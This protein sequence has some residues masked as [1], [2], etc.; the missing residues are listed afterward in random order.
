MT[1]QI[2][3]IFSLLR[4][5]R[6]FLRVLRYIIADLTNSPNQ[7][8][9]TLDHNKWDFWKHSPTGITGTATRDNGFIVVQLRFD[10]LRLIGVK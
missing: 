10:P 5:Y 6:P 9:S 8:S 4:V 1:Y 7:A 3:G 2:K